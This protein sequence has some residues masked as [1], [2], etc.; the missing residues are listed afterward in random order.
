[1][2]IID[3]ANEIADLTIQH[4]LANRPAPPVFTGKCAYC[5]E[6]IEVGRFCDEYCREDFEKMARCNHG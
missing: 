3:I 1:M 4:A 5:R 6:K 2:D